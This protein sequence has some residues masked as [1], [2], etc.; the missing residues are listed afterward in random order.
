MQGWVRMWGMAVGAGMHMGHI[1]GLR[2]VCIHIHSFAHSYATVADC[3]L[4]SMA[5][6]Q[7]ECRIKAC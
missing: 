5:L 7:P 1:T 3:Q 2:Q 4:S 6:D